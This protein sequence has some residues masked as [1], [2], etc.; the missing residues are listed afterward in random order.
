MW[1]RRRDSHFCIFPR[2][3][4]ASNPGSYCAVAATAHHVLAHVNV[5]RIKISFD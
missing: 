1:I 5:M 3:A 4:R 2:R